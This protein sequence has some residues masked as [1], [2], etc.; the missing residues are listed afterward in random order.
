MTV[1]ECLS[2]SDRI[3]LLWEHPVLADRSQTRSLELYKLNPPAR[4]SES[5]CRRTSFV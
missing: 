4:V 5:P 3:L 1:P 2:G